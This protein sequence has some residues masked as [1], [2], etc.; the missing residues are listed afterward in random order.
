MS[1]PLHPT[2][3]VQV[4][5]GELLVHDLTVGDP[6]PQAPTVVLVHGITSNAVTWVTTAAELARRHPGVRLV[7]PDL[8]GR[9][10]SREVTSPAGI[11]AHAADVR[12]IAA[13]LGVKPLLVGH[14]MGGFVVANALAAYPDDFTGVV[15]VDGGFPLALPEGVT[16]DQAVDAVVGP[17]MQRLRMTF[18]DQNA[19]LAY[20]A[21]HPAVGTMLDAPYG[22]MV[23]AYLL[24]DL[25]PAEGGG[26]RSSCI[27]DVVRTDGREL[28]ADAEVGGA[29]PRV[30]RT[31]VPAGFVWA[32]RGLLAQTPGLYD[33]GAVDALDLPDAVHVAHVDSDHYD[34]LFDPAPVGILAD[35]VDS[36]LGE[37]R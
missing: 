16:P 9:A 2:F 18:E 4:E 8:R 36:V 28:M 13:H 6:D 1:E 27:E 11:R 34:M 10:G 37:V 21:E 3:T 12:A 26:V 23:A 35:V 17:A 14:S 30:L 20:W 32:E 22:A 33:A 24:Q 19:Y 31:G 29:A 7:A 25:V 5:G 15:I